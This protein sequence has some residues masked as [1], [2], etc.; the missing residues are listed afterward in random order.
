MKPIRNPKY[1][2]YVRSLPC[3]VSRATRDQYG[4]PNVAAHVRLGGDGGMGMK[5]S[6]TRTVPLTAFLHEKQHAIGERT[7]WTQSR[8]DPQDIII[9]CLI[10]FIGD[11]R[12]VIQQLEQLVEGEG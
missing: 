1:L 5:P 3:S 4:R 6:D 2:A 8:K 12:A 10:G 9:A 7:F 11:K